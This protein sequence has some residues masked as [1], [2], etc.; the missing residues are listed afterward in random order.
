MRPIC[1]PIRGDGEVGVECGAAGVLHDLQRA[2]GSL[3]HVGA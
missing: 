2:L 3:F 1:L